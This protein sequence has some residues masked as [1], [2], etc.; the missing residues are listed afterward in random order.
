MILQNENGTLTRYDGGGTNNASAGQGYG[1]CSTAEATTAKAATLADYEI[2]ENGV[3]AVRFTNAVPANSTLN[4]NSKG[5]KPIYYK[6][7][8]IPS[9]IIRAGDTATFFYDGSY[10]HL[11]AVDRQMEF[12]FSTH[13]AMNAAITAGTVPNGAI[14][15]TDKTDYEV[16]DGVAKPIIK[17]G[18]NLLDNWYFVGGGSQQG[19]GQ[20]PINQRDG[21]VVPPGTNYRLPGQSEVAGVTSDYFSATRNSGGDYEFYINNTLYIAENVVPGYTYTDSGYG[22]DRWIAYKCTIKQDAINNYG[23][24]L[25]YIDPNVIISGE[26]YTISA[27]YKNNTSGMAIRLDSWGD[28]SCQSIVLSG[29]TEESGLITATGV[30]SRSS[31][32][33]RVAFRVGSYLGQADIIAAKLELGSEQTLA[34]Q[35]AQ[36]NWVLNDPPPNYQ[37]ELAKCQRYF[38]KSLNNGVRCTSFVSNAASNHAMTGFVFPVEMRTTPTVELITIEDSGNGTIMNTSDVGVSRTKQGVCYLY[39]NPGRL[40]QG[41]SYYIDFRASADF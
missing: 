14:C 30:F 32:N 20:F 24:L 5:A 22:I 21:L 34:H 2:V 7:S 37:Q 8:A 17:H 41:H 33:Y 28:P 39:D 29:V 36:G 13:A 31:D 3:V 16:V 1:T 40:T 38:F 4:I 35:D 11:T 18:V 25:Q 23:L 12:N 6:G 26:T 10:Y 15:H 27:L 19:G 9:D